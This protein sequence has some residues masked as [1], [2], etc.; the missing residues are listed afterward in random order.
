MKKNTIVKENQKF[1]K[2]IRADIT[3]SFT[4]EP[5]EVYRQLLTPLKN[6]LET[7]GKR[8]ASIGYIQG[9]N[10]IVKEL[11]KNLDETQAFWV[12]VHINET[13]LPVDYYN[14]KLQG[15]RLEHKVL[16]HLL[17]SYFAALVTHLKH[18]NFELD[19][20]PISWII[21]LFMNDLN[22]SAR[23]FVMSAFL[24]KGQKMILRICLIVIDII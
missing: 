8:N 14:N 18:Y 21:S 6:V 7:F 4:G 1:F 9:M 11:L 17:R 19:Y 3:R 5:E 12:F 20:I 13:I 16:Q 23:P 22:D 10:Y 2:E 24:I 15:I